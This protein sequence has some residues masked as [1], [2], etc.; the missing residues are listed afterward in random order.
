MDR[1]AAQDVGEWVVEHKDAIIT[2]GITAAAIAITIASFGAAGPAL[3]PLAIAAGVGGAAGLGGQFIGDVLSS[4]PGSLQLSSW[5]QYVGAF[6]GGAFGG[7]TAYTSKNAATAG[8]VSEFISNSVT[9]TLTLWTNPGSDTTW[10]GSAET[11]LA[12]GGVGC[13]ERGQ[14]CL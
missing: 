14:T 4:K 7:V 5:Q 9:D 6:V 13:W 11:S 12:K 1:N 10:L 2:T 8:F 3:I